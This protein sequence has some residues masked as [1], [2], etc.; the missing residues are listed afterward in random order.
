MSIAALCFIPDWPRAIAEMVSR[1]R[2]A[3]GLLHWHTAAEV[4]RDGH[5]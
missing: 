5:R 2:V 3:I 1:E 4:P